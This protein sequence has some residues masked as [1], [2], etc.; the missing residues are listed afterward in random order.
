[1]DPSQLL[2]QL[3]DIHGTA[4]PGWWP[5]APGW[6]VLAAL[7]LVGL[8]FLGHRLRRR[9]QDRKRRK[10][11]LQA[12]DRLASDYDPVESPRQYLAGLNR[13][14][15]AVALR[16]F[17]DTHCAR[18]EGR[19]WVDFIQTRLPDMANEEA[20]AA[21]ERGPYEVRPEFDADT[22]QSQARA[23]VNRYG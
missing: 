21:L 6:W 19:Q 20:L 8:F 14:F 2:A 12:L 7:F 22:L 15:R 11:W 9:L 17:P 1:M 3:M 4:A 16:A 23:W 10:R 18:L 13:L 5:P